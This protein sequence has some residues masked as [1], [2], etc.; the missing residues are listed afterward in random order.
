MLLFH[1]TRLDR[2]SLRHVFAEGLLP[3][4]RGW[5]HELT[6]ERAFCFLANAPI[7]GRGGDPIFFATG[8]RYRTRKPTEGYVVVVDVP[9]PQLEAS[10]VG[11]FPN[12]E[13][14]QF[15]RS[16]A[17]R[18]RP[19]SYLPQLVRLGR[20]SDAER[21]AF[22]SRG[23]KLRNRYADLHLEGIDYATWCRYADDVLAAR[24]VAAVERAG[25]RTGI[26]W[27]APEVLHC[28]LCVQGMAYWVYELE[29]DDR[30]PLP[31]SVSGARIGADAWVTLAR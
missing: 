4:D 29:P 20:A 25:R 7:A 26:V 10:L 8:R 1:G 24:T 16:Q 31:A 11:V 19:K 18:H 3:S 27:D 28:E 15:L 22:A 9:P 2:E 6:D 30:N 14:E 21:D 17:F 12:V 13:L 5:M 23:P